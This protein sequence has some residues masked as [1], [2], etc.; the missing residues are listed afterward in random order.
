MLCKYTFKV[1]SYE[2]DSVG[3]G[4]GEASLLESYPG[5]SGTI[6]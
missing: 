2:T 4:L 5:D 3:P 1:P 6:Y